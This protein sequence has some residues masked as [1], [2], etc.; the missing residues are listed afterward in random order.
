MKSSIRIIP[1]YNKVVFGNGIIGGCV[2]G[3]LNETKSRPLYFVEEYISEK[4]RDFN[5]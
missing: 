3:T 2:G 1:A 5:G 4:V